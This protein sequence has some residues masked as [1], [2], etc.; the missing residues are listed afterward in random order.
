MG[1]RLPGVVPAKILKRSLS[2][3]KK[4]DSVAVDVPKGHL[5]VYVGDI[6]KKRFVIPLSFLN[7]PSFHDLLSQA[8]EEFGFEHPMGGLTIPCREDA[9][10]DL[11]S[12]LNAP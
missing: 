10:L 5:A 2:N 7:Q 1:F 12:R 9:F 4:A 8:E 11:V 3:S 6:E